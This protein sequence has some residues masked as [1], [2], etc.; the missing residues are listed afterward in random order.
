MV[1]LIASRRLVALDARHVDRVNAEAYLKSGK[2]IRD[3]G[4]VAL[5]PDGLLGL[6][7]FRRKAA[8]KSETKSE[9]KPGT[10]P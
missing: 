5:A 2:E 6:R 4:Y 3:V 10:K 8:A 9:A 1:L 7:L